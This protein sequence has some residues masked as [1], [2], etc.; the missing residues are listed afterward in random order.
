VYDTVI[1]IIREMSNNCEVAAHKLK[2][3][4]FNVSRESSF[5]LILNFFASLLNPHPYQFLAGNTGAHRQ[6]H[7]GKI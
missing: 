4:R 1:Q 5:Y 2:W 7:H 3:Q 6:Y